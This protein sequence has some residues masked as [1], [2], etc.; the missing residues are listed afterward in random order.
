MSQKLIT[1][2]EAVCNFGFHLFASINLLQK[3]IDDKRPPLQCATLRCLGVFFT[4]IPFRCLEGYLP[5]ILGTSRENEAG[6]V[7]EELDSRSENRLKL[8]TISILSFNREIVAG[9]SILTT[10]HELSLANL[11]RNVVCGIFDIDTTVDGGDYGKSFFTERRI[12][13]GNYTVQQRVISA[14]IDLV[15]ASALILCHAHAP[16]V[17]NALSVGRDAMSSSSSCH[18]DPTAEMFPPEFIENVLT[19]GNHELRVG[20]PV[21]EET[22]KRMTEKK[23]PSLSADSDLADTANLL[24]IYAGTRDP[25][26]SLPPPIL[27]PLVLCIPLFEPSDSLATTAESSSN[28]SGKML[29]SNGTVLS[30]PRRFSSSNSNIPSSQYGFLEDGNGSISLDGI[31]SDIDRSKLSALKKS[32]SRGGSRSQ[33]R[34]CMSQPSLP[35][36]MSPDAPG[37]FVVNRTEGADSVGS[38]SPASGST[39]SNFFYKKAVS[40]DDFEVNEAFPVHRKSRSAKSDV[41]R[42]SGSS[43]SPYDNFHRS[44]RLIGTLKEGDADADADFGNCDDSENGK[45]DLDSEPVPDAIAYDDADTDGGARSCASANNSHSI[46]RNGNMSADMLALVRESFPHDRLTRTADGHTRANGHAHSNYTLDRFDVLDGSSHVQNHSGAVSH[47]ISGIRIQ[48]LLHPNSNQA[49]L[50]KRSIDI[51]MSLAKDSKQLLAS[52]SLPGPFLSLDG[53]EHSLVKNGGPLFA[54]PSPASSLKLSTD[55]D[56]SGRLQL[57]CD[58]IWDTN[59]SITLGPIGGHGLVKKLRTL[60]SPCSDLRSDSGFFASSPLSSNPIS[61]ISLGS[62]T[63]SKADTMSKSRDS[64]RFQREQEIKPRKGSMQETAPPVQRDYQLAGVRTYHYPIFYTAIFHHSYPLQ[65]ALMPGNYFEA[66]QLSDLCRRHC[67]T[68]LTTHFSP[69]LLCIAGNF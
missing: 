51:A 6:D 56:R 32:K 68:L 18:M 14:A 48:G 8:A 9:I 44:N 29:T 66:I 30:P 52:A 39:L 69:N 45:F 10:E 31:D 46:S 1:F 47:D 4:N 67:P 23:L 53:L 20:Q 13:T 62:L 38:R 49:R 60:R 7:E 2:F 12:S 36:C 26:L 22:L 3:F 28:L 5:T 25:I 34:G 59:P 65:L 43:P 33:R 63:A 41:F 54:L 27:G 40:N 57:S 17:R 19:D 16:L 35:S 64:G 50:G 24:L 61:P 58:S 55:L 37:F 15:A 42:D 11:T 21:Q